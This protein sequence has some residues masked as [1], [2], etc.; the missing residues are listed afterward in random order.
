[1]NS[2]A[3][4]S[5]SSNDEANQLNQLISISICD[6]FPFLTNI[7]EKFY[8]WID[9]DLVPETIA[10][11]FRE[12]LQ[13]ENINNQDFVEHLFSNHSETH[14]L[15][16]LLGFLF[17]KH[18]Y[19]FSIFKL[20]ALGLDSELAAQIIAY[21]FYEKSA[22]NGNQYGQLFHGIEL[23]MRASESMEQGFYYIEKAAIQGN[24]SAM[25]LLTSDYA[26]AEK[27]G[28]FGRW[29][30]NKKFKALKKCAFAG[31]IPAEQDLFDRYLEGFGTSKDLHEA[32][33]LYY[34]QHLDDDVL[35]SDH[36]YRKM[37]LR[38]LFLKNKY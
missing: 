36:Y 6:T 13:A 32:L 12:I 19:F 38:D 16:P 34:H 17:Q 29:N 37:Q 9:R 14:I 1:M 20:N 3:I 27:P 31:S 11:R 7:I 26:Y 18:K 5:C 8:Y 4:C 23:L 10:F 22:E 24:T 21:D 25:V 30:E 15:L 35:W 2:D 33:K 28:I